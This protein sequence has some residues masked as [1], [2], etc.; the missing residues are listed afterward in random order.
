MEDQNENIEERRPA[1]RIVRTAAPTGKAKVKCVNRRS[2]RQCREPHM[3]KMGIS[4]VEFISS[5]RD[6]L[7]LEN[8][9]ADEKVAIGQKIAKHQRGCESP[10]SVAR[11]PGRPRSRC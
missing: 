2:R 10:M 11:H 9:L 3:I 6:A 5:I 4:G 1:P 7:A 8:S